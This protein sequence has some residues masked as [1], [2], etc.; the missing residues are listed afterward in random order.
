VGNA[1][2][3]GGGKRITPDA[4]MDDGQFSVTV[5]GPCRG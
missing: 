3:Y 2:Q 4:R 1:P 5:V